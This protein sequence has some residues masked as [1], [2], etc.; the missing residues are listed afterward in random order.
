MPSASLRA[1][2]AMTIA[3]GVFTTM[4]LFGFR[5]FGGAAQALLLNNYHRTDDPLATLARLATGLSILCGYPL[6]FAALKSSFFNAGSEICSKFGEGG[7]KM[8]VRFQTDQGLQK[9][10]YLIKL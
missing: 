8:A 4:M 5:T 6:M 1:S 10:E 9:S 7:K 2:V 3:F